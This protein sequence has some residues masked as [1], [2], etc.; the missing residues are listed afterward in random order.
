MMRARLQSLRE[1]QKK[2]I[3]VFDL[4]GGLPGLANICSNVTNIYY[5]T[6]KALSQSPGPTCSGPLSVSILVQSSSTVRAPLRQ[7]WSNQGYLHYR[8]S[9][10]FVSVYA[11]NP[12]L[13]SAYLPYH[14]PSSNLTRKTKP[15]LASTVFSSK[16][17]T[18]PYTPI[19]TSFLPWCPVP[20]MQHSY[21]TALA[22]ATD[23]STQ[24]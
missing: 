14:L 11:G 13:A 5:G 6:A 3:F 2:E 12:T 15:R 24:I 7:Y 16:L 8:R 17:F 18:Y 10:R 22:V 21:A 1:C 4:E 20:L 19:S 9:F 23:P